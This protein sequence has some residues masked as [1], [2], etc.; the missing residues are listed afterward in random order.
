MEK[1]KR[2]FFF[3]QE[4]Y[5]K[6][7]SQPYGGEGQVSLN[8]SI[9]IVAL[10]EE[11]YLPGILGDIL[12]QSYPHKKIEL[13]LVDSMSEDGTRS[14]M[15]QFA[16][17]HA[18]QFLNIIVSDNPGRIQSC[19]WNRVIGLFTTGALIRI[20]AHSS[21]PGDFVKNNVAV[22]EEGEFVAGGARPN[23]AM[24]ASPW[25]EVLL[26]AESSMF[27]SSAASFR[28][29]GKRAYV[30]SFFHGA[31]RREVFE[32][33]GKFR[34]DLGRT[35]DNEFHYRIRQKGCRLCMAPEILSYQMIRPSLPAMC[36]QKFGNGYWVGLTAG[37]CPGCLSVYHFVPFA[38]VCGIIV[39]T[40]LAVC[41][42]PFLAVLMWTLYWLLAVIMAA[43]AV[44]AGRKRDAALGV[45]A[46]Q[47]VLPALFFLLHVSYGLGTLLGILNLPFWRG[48]QWWK[49]KNT[50]GKN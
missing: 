48:R 23:I 49:K 38:F 22:L 34:E 3:R 37:I 19:G 31:Y 39:T 36:R 12:R 35:E 44:R 2:L 45:Y 15:Q 4:A 32:R 7:D 16:R 8:I 33:A 29:A 1:Q 10:N 27:G 21:I 18:G 41:A 28:R 9:G 20:D 26:M 46:G 30:K 6:C 24:E 11:K 13:V 40:I 14:L 50:R 43:G 25:Q 17:E 5:N 47:F 42:H